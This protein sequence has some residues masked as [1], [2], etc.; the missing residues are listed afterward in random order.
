M[1]VDGEPNPK[2]MENSP[3]ERP[4][5]RQQ[6][7]HKPTSVSC[8][9][10]YLLESKQWQ[11]QQQMSSTSQEHASTH[12]RRPRHL[13]ALLQELQSMVVAEEGGCIF[14]F[15][16]IAWQYWHMAA[17]QTTDH[18]HQKNT[19]VQADRFKRKKKTAGAWLATHRDHI[20][21]CWDCVG[22]VGKLL[23][24]LQT[25]DRLLQGRKKQPMSCNQLWQTQG[26]AAIP[27]F[28]CA[29][30]TRTLR[31]LLLLRCVRRR[32]ASSMRLRLHR[33]LLHHSGEHRLSQ[34]FTGTCFR[35]VLIKCAS[36]TT[37]TP[38]AAARTGISSPSL[39]RSCNRRCSISKSFQDP[40]SCGCEGCSPADGNRSGTELS[41]PPLRP[42]IW[43]AP[44]V[45][46]A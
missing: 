1:C 17:A 4:N 44:S 25:R 13:A 6:P 40:A 2:K 38:P 42:P 29:K 19:S 23:Q 31:L 8:S 33:L 34:M 39:A 32:R 45:P 15:H 43:V 26:A 27:R 20:L 10:L 37:A 3:H 41:D 12:P 9:V 22:G 46:T 7:R 14:L 24:Q 36:S 18:H 21:E 35:A 11:D 16:R 30:L 28:R 5:A